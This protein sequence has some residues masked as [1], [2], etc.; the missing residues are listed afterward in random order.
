MQQ[1]CDSFHQIPTSPATA[2]K[3]GQLRVNAFD[4]KTREGQ[5]HFNIVKNRLDVKR[6]KCPSGSYLALERAIS[7]HRPGTVL[8]VQSKLTQIFERQRG[9]S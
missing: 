5:F 4:G 8:G 6:W 7:F 1:S 3:S 9:L 2:T